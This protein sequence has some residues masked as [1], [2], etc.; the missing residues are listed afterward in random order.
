[1]D[2]A[3]L[4][5]GCANGIGSVEFDA[6]AKTEGFLP[7]FGEDMLSFKLGMIMVFLFLRNLRSGC[8]L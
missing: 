2:K 4:S 5:H 7:Y 3:D 6:E 8:S 1:M